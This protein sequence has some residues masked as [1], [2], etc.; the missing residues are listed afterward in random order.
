MVRNH[1]I[2]ATKCSLCLNTKMTQVHLQNNV[3][4]VK[5]HLKHPEGYI[6]T[7]VCKEKQVIDPK[8][9]EAT[10]TTVFPITNVT[11]DEGNIWNANSDIMKNK[12]D[13]VY[14]TVVHWNI[15]KHLKHPMTYL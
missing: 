10:S 9:I 13:D 7:C 8:V 6:N 5:D 15:L 11:D 2:K 14:N 12:L 1:T 4:S 3:P